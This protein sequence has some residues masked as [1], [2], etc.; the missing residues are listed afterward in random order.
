[1]SELEIALRKAGWITSKE[2]AGVLGVETGYVAY[3]TWL[4][5]LTPQVVGRSRWYR[6]SDVDAYKRSH[7]RVGMARRERDLT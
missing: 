2:A 4:C 7:P 3:L 1:M 5:K 6:R